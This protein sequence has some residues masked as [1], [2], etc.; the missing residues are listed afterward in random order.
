V[1]GGR[2]DTWPLSD[3]DTDADCDAVTDCDADTDCVADAHT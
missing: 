2:C 3:A 1:A